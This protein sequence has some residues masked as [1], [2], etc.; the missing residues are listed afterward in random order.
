MIKS[1]LN[2]IGG[3]F[4]I[5]EQLFYFFPQN[6]NNFVDLFAGGLDVSININANNIFCNDINYKLIEIYKEMQNLTIDVL[7]AKID[8]TIIRFNLSK[9]NKE[10]Y[11]NLRRQYNEHQNPI[12]LYVLIC[13]SFNYQIRFNSK[14]E[15]N[16]PFGKERSSFSDIMRDNLKKFHN[17]ILPFHFDARDFRDYNL[18]FLGEN[19]FVYADPPYLISCGSY[20][21]GKR[22]FKGW[23]AEDDL[24]LFDTLNVINHQGSRFALSNVIT[25]KGRNNEPLIEWAEQ[26]HIHFINKNY[27]NSN[28][29]SRSRLNET[30][31]VLIT[32]F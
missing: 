23:T 31:E 20:N 29:Q 30:Q 4:K 6:I 15:Y 12:D 25:H 7:L 9:T 19:D 11:L 24:A 10:G 5:L 28:Y 16:N 32:N 18:E 14:M 27:N 13:F 1:P 2:Y 8:E 3:K 26:Y 17:A 21:D 22:G